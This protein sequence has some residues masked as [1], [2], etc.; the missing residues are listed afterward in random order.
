MDMPL[1]PTSVLVQREME[2]SAISF[3]YK[4]AYGKGAFFEA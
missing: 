1:E 4:L 3:S 2:K